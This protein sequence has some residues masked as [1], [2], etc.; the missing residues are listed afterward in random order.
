[1]TRLLIFLLCLILTACGGGGHS[2]HGADVL[3]QDTEVGESPYELWLKEGNTGSEQDYLE[4]LLTD[5]GQTVLD[6]Y[7]SIS[8]M[9][10]VYG[11][12]VKHMA[13]DKHGGFNRI[14]YG[15]DNNYDSPDQGND[16]GGGGYAV[17]N[18]KELN[19]ANY[20]VY[21]QYSTSSRE[22]EPSVSDNIFIL[23]LINNREGVNKNIYTPNEGA[24]FKG[25]TLAYLHEGSS[26]NASSAYEPVFIKGDAEYVYSAT[27]P[28]LTLD[29]ENYYKFIFETGDRVTVSGTND[30]GK[31]Y[32]DIN[33][34]SIS[35][36][37]DTYYND[38]ASVHPL[39]GHIGGDAPRY[40]FLKKGDTEEMVGKYNFNI[41]YGYAPNIG[42]MAVTGAFGGTKQ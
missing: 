7:V 8:Q 26:F 12:D 39:D 13:W 25:G 4:S 33:T 5:N 27:N 34:G 10:Q 30:T 11:W 9:A 21:I 15:F 37:T 40:G 41:G 22:F 18:E 24:V 3:K 19:L 28:K 23:G 2:H 1:M 6:R 17:Y 20:G 38:Y 35:L 31:Q 14:T 32:Y 42:Q 16:Y 36:N 29:F